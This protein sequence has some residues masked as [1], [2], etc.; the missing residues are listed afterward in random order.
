MVRV[1]LERLAERALGTEDRA[2]AERD[3]AAGE[4]DLGALGA[5]AAGAQPGE[6]RGGAPGFAERRQDARQAQIVLVH[7][8]LAVEDGLRRLPRGDGVASRDV[9]LG[10]REHVVGARPASGAQ[11]PLRLLE[12]GHRVVQ[13][14]GR[15]E[16]LGVLEPVVVVLGLARDEV[17]EEAE[18]LVGVAEA[19]T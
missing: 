5:V 8:D 13:P 3:P 19:C 12:R 7:V 17:G 6:S 11:D 14:A 1:G 18:R 9:N 4:R 16:G 15:D 2:A 10:H